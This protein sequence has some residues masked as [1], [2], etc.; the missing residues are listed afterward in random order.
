MLG[1]RLVIERFKALGRAEPP[2]PSSSETSAMRAE[3]PPSLL[4]AKIDRA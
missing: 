2:A 3:A 4:K 1:L